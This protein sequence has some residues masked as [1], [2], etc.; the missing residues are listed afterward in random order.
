MYYRIKNKFELDFLKNIETANII[1]SI[2]LDRM[3]DVLD[4]LDTN[5]G[6]TRASNAMG[7]YI[8]FFPTK[9]DYLNIAPII[10]ENYN[11]DSSLY[12]YDDELASTENMSWK[13][14]LYLLS[15]EDSLIFIYSE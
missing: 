14:K 9:E 11:I 8:L 5:Y 2:V 13:E 1:P 10:Y 7:G 6:T 15:S 4:I 12:E 3:S